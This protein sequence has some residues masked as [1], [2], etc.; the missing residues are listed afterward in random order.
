MARIDDLIAEALRTV[1]QKP[2]DTAKQSDKKRFSERLSHA[3]AEAFAE[4]LRA[5]GLSSARPGP[6]GA[7][8]RKGAERRMSGGIGAKKVDV[9]WATEE[10]GLLLGISIKTINFRDNRTKNFQK[11]LTNRR[12]DMLFEAVTL[13]RRFP[14]AVLAGFF[15][16][17]HE[18]A[19][20]HTD[21]RDSTF[22]NAHQR[23]RLFTGRMDP[24]GRDEQYERLF[25][26][27][28][29]SN[30]SN[31]FFEAYRVGEPRKP[32]AMAEAMGELMQL[33]AERDPDFYEADTGSVKRI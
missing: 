3:L 26:V 1:G 10:S 14:Y 31:P 17:D 22:H 4:E 28:L 25:V 9:T 12:G 19:H 8:G 13:H 6:S 16:L 32:V 15:I 33:I 7:L 21:N 30:Q 11:N 29:N 24:A 20:D 23:L 5:R 27:L 18:A 2:L